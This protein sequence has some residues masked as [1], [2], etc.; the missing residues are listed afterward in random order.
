[1]GECPLTEMELLGESIFS[2]LVPVLNP[3]LKRLTL[4]SAL[5]QGS[6]L[7]STPLF[8]LLVFSVF[9]LFPLGCIVAILDQTAV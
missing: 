3:L 2:E 5:P 8:P 1:M 9:L 7:R 6:H 4:V